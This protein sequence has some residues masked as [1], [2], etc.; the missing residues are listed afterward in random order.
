[1]CNQTINCISVAARPPIILEKFQITYP[2]RPTVGTAGILIDG[3][4][5]GV[6]NANS[7]IRDI[8]M[9]N[10]D[11]GIKTI[12]IERFT[13]DHLI[14]DGTWATDLYLQWVAV[15]GSGDS[16]VIN[17]T[18]SSG[19]VDAHITVLSGGGLRIVN[20][21]M[22]GGNIG[23]KVT[24]NQLTQSISPLFIQN[25]SMEMQNYNILIGRSAGVTEAVGNVVITGNELYSAL[26][27]IQLQASTT[28]PATPWVSGGAVSGN[29]FYTNSGG[30]AMSIGGSKDFNF[31][32]N[33]CA[34]GGSTCIAIDGASTANIGNTANAKGAGVL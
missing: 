25:N 13:F 1:V 5:G 3:P 29:F 11:I 27:G 9:I 24:P 22:N 20:N 10:P 16:G 8:A 30:T 12:N 17:S 32:G 26:F 4:G 2:L 31:V 28:N 6:S 15:P 7:L 34:G 23:V 21:K 33:Q 14:M 19:N 18:F